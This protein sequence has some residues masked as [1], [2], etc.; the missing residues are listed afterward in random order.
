MPSLGDTGMTAT[1]P[2]TELQFELQNDAAFRGSFWL[3]D[4]ISVTALPDTASTLSLLS[5]AFLG[6]VALRRKL[7]C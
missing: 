3:L 2:L 5:F 1:S 7:S 4:D 6:L